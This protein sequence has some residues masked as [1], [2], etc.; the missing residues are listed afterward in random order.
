MVILPVHRLNRDGQGAPVLLVPGLPPFLP[1]RRRRR[2]EPEDQVLGAAVEDATLVEGA[3]LLG[4]VATRA[5]EGAGED[6]L[7]VS[8]SRS[9]SFRTCWKVGNGR[10]RLK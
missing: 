1:L 6:L 9:R 5:V 7:E 8:S 2:S 3:G 10:A 4:A